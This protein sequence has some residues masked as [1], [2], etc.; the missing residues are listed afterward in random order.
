MQINFDN[1]LTEKHKDKVLM[2]EDKVVCMAMKKLRKKKFSSTNVEIFMNWNLKT[3][4]KKAI[5]NKET[6][7]LKFCFVFENGSIIL[8]NFTEAEEKEML[9]LIAKQ[10]IN[11]INYSEDRFS[12]LDK[13]IYE[14]DPLNFVKDCVTEGI[15][16][17][18]VSLRGG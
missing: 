14:P 7:S 4:G 8:W 16:F 1:F 17:L 3:Y 2:I 5:T 13:H 15:I 11:K 6:D 9:T 18:R 10:D 12:Y